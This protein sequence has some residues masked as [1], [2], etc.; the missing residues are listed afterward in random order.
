M[1]YFIVV[2]K[3]KVWKLKI[4]I[5]INAAIACF[6]LWNTFHGLLFKSKWV[7]WY[8]LGPSTP[9]VCGGFLGVLFLCSSILGSLKRYLI[10]DGGK[11]TKTKQRPYVKLNISLL[12][13]IRDRLLKLLSPSSPHTGSWVSPCVYEVVLKEQ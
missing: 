4:A 11:K 13:M 5:I 1:G 7:K 8:N 10:F 3:N 2:L 6:I 9:K 12:K